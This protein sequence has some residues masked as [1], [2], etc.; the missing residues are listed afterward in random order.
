MIA[1][2]QKFEGRT[3]SLDGGTFND[4]QFEHCVLLYSGTLPVMLKGSSFKECR[5]EFVGSA[6]NT[7]SFMRFLYEHGEKALIEAIFE[8]VRTE[9]ADA[10]AGHAAHSH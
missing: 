7:V 5:W 10:H 6:G 3:I 2:G 4:C 8:S 1:I 9:D